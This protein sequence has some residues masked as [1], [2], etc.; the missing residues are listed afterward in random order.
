MSS[1]PPSADSKATSSIPAAGCLASPTAA[2]LHARDDDTFWAARRVAAFTDEMI[3]A[4][5]RAGRY[6]DPAAEALLA[7]VLIKRR[8]KI[9]EA[10]LP[11]I[12]P[13]V[14]FVLS[15]DGRLGFRNAAVDAG[16]APAPPSGYRASWSE[17]DNAT[18]QSQS[19]GPVTTSVSSELAAP[20][21]LPSAVGTYLRIQVSAAGPARAEWTRPVDVYF[22][23]TAGEWRLVGLERMP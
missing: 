14:D 16:V 21:A 2:F 17:F 10:Y 1:S 18:G 20:R 22:R 3:R 9:A 23:R 6:S 5:V 12:N 11:A 7:D 4:V 15:G 13:L 19:L 8:R